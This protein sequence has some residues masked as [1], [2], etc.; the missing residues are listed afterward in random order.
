MIAEAFRMHTDRL[1][2]HPHVVVETFDDHFEVALK[3]FL[4]FPQLALEAIEP[5]IDS[6]ES[7]LDP[8]KSNIDP[9]EA[10][11]HRAFEL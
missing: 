11:I 7:V 8:I 10:G 5:L 3:A 6:T 1:G 4:A 9:A 2:E